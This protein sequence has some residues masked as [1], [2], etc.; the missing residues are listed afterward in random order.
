M[1]G[2]VALSYLASYVGDKA[3]SIVGSL[4]EP[5]VH[6]YISSK[7]DEIQAPGLR[8]FLSDIVD[9]TAGMAESKFGTGSHR[10][11]GKKKSSR[12]KK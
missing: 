6:N 3:L 1:A 8:N 7:V 4:A 11:T 5:A 10:S 9:S 2:A 12:K